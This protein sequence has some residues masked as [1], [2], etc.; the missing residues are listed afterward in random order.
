[1]AAHTL[2][3]QKNI[4]LLYERHLTVNLCKLWLTVST[5]VLITETF[6]DL[7]IAVDTSNHRKL[8]KSLWRLRKSIELTRI[9]A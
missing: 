9:H 1:M 2:K 3:H 7:E 8:L 6:T 4:L 5:K